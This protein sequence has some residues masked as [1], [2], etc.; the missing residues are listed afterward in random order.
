MRQLPMTLHPKCSPGWS[1]RLR[2]PPN[3]WSCRF[4][5][6][7]SA[8]SATLLMTTVACLTAETES[9]WKSGA[10]ALGFNRSFFMVFQRWPSA[11]W[12]FFLFGSALF[13]CRPRQ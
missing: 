11:L 9:F 8:F 1:G 7:A 3:S 4:V 13:D 5:I 12:L 6:S 10:A 2:F